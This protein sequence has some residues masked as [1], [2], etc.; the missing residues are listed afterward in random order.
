MKGGSSPR[1]DPVEAAA[2]AS[3]DGKTVALVFGTVDFFEILLNWACHAL[4]LGIRWFV[5]VT[6]DQQLE[7]KLMALDAVKTH[8]LLLPAVREGN[9][10]LTKLN[11]IG[12]R[13]RFGVSILQRGLNV[14]HSDADALWIKD[15]FPLFAGGDIVAERIWGKPLSVVKEWGA[16]IC[17]GFY[18]LRSGPSVLSLASTVQ[19]EIQ[20][21]RTQKPRWQASDQYF[22][23]QVLQRYG[24][25]WANGKKMAGSESMETKFF[26]RNASVG[27]AHA[28]TGR[29]LRLVM[30]AHSLVPRACPVLSAA[31]RQSMQATQ[32]DQEHAQQGRRKQPRGKARYWEM[33]LRSSYVL[34]CFPPEKKQ[35]SKEKRIVF[36]VWP[37]A[38][39]R[40]NQPMS[41]PIAQVMSVSAAPPSSLAFPADCYTVY[42]ILHYHHRAILRTPRRSC[43]LRGG[44]V[45]GV[46]MSSC[47]VDHGNRTASCPEDTHWQRAPPS[48]LPYDRLVV[49]LGFYGTAVHVIL[50]LASFHTYR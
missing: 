26:D 20:R 47:R 19:T 3:P 7:A 41:V 25:R 11:V 27:L 6:M 45:C 43:C 40:R 18:F 4:A 36:M 35:A 30:L 14:V 10:T 5:L 29:P 17:T 12:E 50:Q 38:L 39:R 16:G 22:I 46:W 8:V 23:N 28:P 2:R 21:K 48:K 37:R 32:Y 42:L 49:R 33:L 15:P 13:Q 31:E 34:H 44:R 9:I 24:V 1:V